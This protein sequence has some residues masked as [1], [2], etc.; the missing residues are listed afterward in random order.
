MLSSNVQIW[1]QGNI[2]RLIITLMIKRFSAWNQFSEKLYWLEFICFLDLGV[3]GG[4]LKLNLLYYLRFENS[5]QGTLIL[6]TGL[7]DQ[8]SCFVF[9]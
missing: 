2:K 4:F 9:E 8:A 5:Y 1:F 7:N 6:I 3:Y